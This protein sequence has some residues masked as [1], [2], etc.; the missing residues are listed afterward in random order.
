MKLHLRNMISKGVRLDG[1]KFD[2]YRNVEV[3]YGISPSAEGSARV[4]LGDTEVIA[5]VKMSIERPFP[6]TEEEG[7][8]M[9]S[10][11]LLPLSSPEYESGP[12]SIKSIE[13]AR[14]VDRA[15]RESKALDVKKLCIKKA[16]EVW[17]VMI[18]VYPINDAGN[19]FDAASLA[20]IAALKNA[21]IP[22]V[23]D[24]KVDYKKKGTKSLP[25]KKDLPIECTIIKVGDKLIVDPSNEEEKLMEARLTV[26]TIGK[27]LCA[28]QK[29]GVEGLTE[30]EINE[31]MAI[32]VKKTDELRKKLK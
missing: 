24:G 20:A 17:T 16:E 15:I 18:D 19:L 26:G 27:D 32:A 31:M 12:P 3:E 21:R 10:A 23:K 6:D 13:L 14:V 1:R 25:L 11:E 5:G 30:D 28:M 4:K 8:L 2:E 22:P 29:G 9:V 7:I